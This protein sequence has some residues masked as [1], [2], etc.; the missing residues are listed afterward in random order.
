M[1]EKTI[2]EF[3]MRW[4]CLS[5]SVG[6]YVKTYFL[7]TFYETLYLLAFY[8]ILL[9]LYFNYITWHMFYF[10]V[11]AKYEKGMQDFPQAKVQSVCFL[12]LLASFDVKCV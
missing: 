7:D 11:L 5:I 2:C 10:K 3:Y 8:S 9:L 1:H 12:L 4:R 6:S